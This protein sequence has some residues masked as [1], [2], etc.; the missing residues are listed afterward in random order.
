MNHILEANLGYRVE[1]LAQTRGGGE[2]VDLLWV[3]SVPTNSA[4]TKSKN[5]LPLFNVYMVPVF[6][7]DLH[8]ENICFTNS[9][10]KSQLKQFGNVTGTKAYCVCLHFCFDYWCVA[11]SYYS[12]DTLSLFSVLGFLIVSPK[13]LTALCFYF[14]IIWF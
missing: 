14:L 13:K 5:K 3:Q 1:T 4:P 9:Q 8:L 7:P 12:E 10:I 6:H 2:Y 11:A